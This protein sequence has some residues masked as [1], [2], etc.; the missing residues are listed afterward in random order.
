MRF[1]NMSSWHAGVDCG[2]YLERLSRAFTSITQYSLDVGLRAYWMLHSPTTPRCR[3]TFKAADRS[4]W[5]SSSGRV[6]EGATTIES[7]VWVPR[8][9]KFSMLQQMIVF[10]G[11]ISTLIGRSEMNAHTS[12]ASRTTSY[13]NSFQ[14]FMLRSISTCGLRLRLFA[15]RSRNSSGLFAKPEPRPPSVNA[16]RKM[17]G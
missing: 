7:P 2:A 15:E 8:G 4:I 17:T 9:S 12:A 1:A 5:Y 3:I 11:N 16:E 13:S 6:C 14:P 10:W